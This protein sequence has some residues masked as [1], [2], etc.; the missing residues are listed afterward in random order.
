MFIRF[1]RI[2]ERD[3][4]THTDRQTDRDTQTPHD[5][6]GR[7]YVQ[8]RAAKNA[9]TL[10]SCSFDK[11]GLI[12]TTFGKQHQH[13]FRNDMHIQLSL[14]FHFYVF[15][16][17]LNN[18]NGKDAKQVNNVFSSVDCWWLWKGWLYS[19]LA[20]K[21]AGFSSADVQ[22]DVLLP[23]RMHTTA[24]SI[25]QHQRFVICLSMCHWC[26]ASSRWCRGLVSCT[27]NV[28]TLLHQS[29]NS[30]VDRLSGSTG[31]FGGNIGLSGEIK[32]GVSC[33]RIWTVSRA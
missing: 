31:L 15:Y 8:H 6:I 20:L 11:R 4:H 2:H 17:L 16:L 7:A 5:G 3:R 9:P 33:W 24:F 29:P 14:F 10:E 19:V 23:S 12:L 26:N 30:V 1:D 21:S 13:T 32:S 28:P 27:H 22:S 18:C 25:D